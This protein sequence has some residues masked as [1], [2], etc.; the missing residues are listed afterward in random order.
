MA[1]ET[2]LNFRNVDS[3][4]NINAR[5]AGLIPKGIVKGGQVVPEPAS[6]QVRVKGD[7]I[8]PFVL[9]AFA[10]DGMVIREMSEEHVLP[11]TAG[12]TSV[13]VLRAKYVAAVGGTI[14]GFEMMSLGAYQT[15]PDQEALIRLCSISPPSGVTAVLTEHI[16]MG[17]RDSI[18]GFT[19]KIVRGVVDTKEDLPAVSGFPAQAEINFL[20]NTFA[21]GTTIT[22][23]TPVG[24]VAFPI[25]SAGSWKLASPNEPGLSRLNPSQK[26]VERDAPLFWNPDGSGHGLGIKRNAATGV[27]T[28]VTTEQHGFFDGSSNGPEVRGVFA[29]G[30]NIYAATL[31]GLAISTNSGMDWSNKIGNGLGSVYCYGVYVEDSTIYAATYAGLSISTDGGSSWINKNT[32][33]GLGSSLVNGVFVSGTTIYAATAGGLSISTDSG[34]TW[35]NKTT[36]NGIGSNVVYCVYASG[37]KIYAGTAGGLSISIDGGTTWTTKT[38][39]DGLGS[40]YVYG[41]FAV[42]SKIYAAT[43]GGLALS[44]DD[45]ATWSNKT[46]THGLG[47][48]YV[49]SVYAVGASIYAG[50]LGGLSIS[51]DNGLT[52]ANKTTTNGLGNNHVNSVYAVGARVY[53]A[54]TGGVS[55]S[56]DSG[57]TW[58]NTLTSSGAITTIRISECSNAKA[59]QL[60]LIKEVIDDYTFTVQDNESLDAWTGTGG[61][62]IDINVEAS[63]VVKL[64]TGI[65]HNLVPGLDR[66]RIGGASNPSFNSNSL[67]FVVADA[68]DSRTLVF[69]Q[70]GYPTADAG[71]G[72][73]S[74]EGYTIPN[75]GVEIGESAI[76]TAA[77]FER[78]LNASLLGTDI[79]AIAI[80]S[81]NQLE[82]MKLGEVGNVFTLSKI[83][84]GVSPANQTIILSGDHFSGGTDP[85]PS[86]SNIDLQAGDLYVVILGESGMLE[87]WGYDGSIFRNLT[88]AATATM[89]DFHRRNQFLNEGHITENQKDALVGT[90]GV[91]SATNKFVTA[92]DTSVLTTD[93]AAAL[94]GADGVAPNSGNRYLTEARRRGE[95]G[96]VEVPSGQ[97]WIPIPLSDGS[98]T[99]Q[100]IVGDDNTNPTVGNSSSKAIPFFN[101]VRTDTLL[102]A[103]GPTEYS[104]VDFT[105]V[106][107]TKV[108]VGVWP[109]STELLPSAH[110]DSSGV[111]PLPSLPSSQS[112]LWVQLGDP[113]TGLNKIPDNGSATLLFSRVIT[114]RS[115]KPSADMYAPPQRILPAALQD[116]I[117]KVNELRF[118]AG[119]SISA[120][121]ITSKNTILTFPEGL[122]SA[123]NVQGFTLR[124]VVNSQ[125]VS[126]LDAFSIDFEAGS[127]GTGLIEAFTPVKLPGADRWTKYLLSLTP[128]GKIKV[129]HIKD[130]LETTSDNAFSSMLSTVALPSMAFSDGSYTF[131]CIGVRLSGA[132]GTATISDLLPTSIEL[133]PYQGTNEREPCAPIICGDGAMSFGHFTGPDA[134]IR[135]LNLAKAG[136]TIRLAPGTYEG[137]LLISKSDITI[138]GSGGAVLTYASATTAALIVV[139]SR[140][141]LKDLIFNCPIALDIQG[142]ADNLS[143]SGIVFKANV[144]TKIK[145]PVVYTFGGSDVTPLLG[146][147]SVANTLAEGAYVKFY[148]NQPPLENAN[149]YFVRNPT[150]AYFHVSATSDGTPIVFSSTGSGSFG[151]GKIFQLEGE[152]QFNHWTV[153]DG[154]NKYGVGDFNSPSALQEVHDDA[155]AQAGD[156]I[157]VLPGTYKRLSVTRDKLHYKGLGGGHVIIDGE[158]STS[159]CITVYGSYNQFENFCLK[160]CTKGIECKSGATYNSFASSV[161][162]DTDIVTAIVIEATSGKHY[163]HHPIISGRIISGATVTQK[164]PEVTIG[165]GATSWGDYVGA[166]AIDQAISGESRGTKLL[167]RSGNYNAINSQGNS[168]NDFIIEGAGATTIIDAKGDADR[169]IK[170]VGSG[171]RISGVKLQ[172]LGNESTNFSTFG[173]EVTGSDNT[174]ENIRF[175]DIGSSRIEL[176]KRYNV[177]SG[178]RNRFTTHTGAATGYVNWTVGDGTHSFGD[179]VGSITAAIQALPTQPKGSD[180]IFSARTAADSN[181]R[182]TVIFQAAAGSPLTFTA[183]DL[184]R[185]LNINSAAF[186]TNIGTYRITGQNPPVAASTVESYIIA[187]RADLIAEISSV[188]FSNTGAFYNVAGAAKAIQL[189]DGANA[190]HY[191]WFKVTGGS[192]TQTDP[193]LSG[194]GHQ[195]SVLLADTPAQVATKFAAAVD[196]LAAFIAPVPGAAI[197][198]VTNAVAGAATDISTTGVELP[199]D[200]RP[201]VVSVLTQGVGSLD[202]KYFT[203]VHRATG[204]IVGVWF[205]AT[206]TTTQP[207]MGEAVACQVLI[208]SGASATDVALALVGALPP[209]LFSISHL[210]GSS[211]SIAQLTA[212][213]VGNPSMGTSGCEL[214]ITEGLDQMSSS[215]FLERTDGISFINEGGLTFGGVNW[216]F[217]TGSKI[218][219]LPGQ[220]Q[221]FSIPTSRND[222]DIEA[223]GGGGDTMIVGTD[224]TTTLLQIEG[225]RCRVKGF[226]FCGGDPLACVA[227]RVNGSNN[228]FEANRYETAIRYSFGAK[229]VGN[230]VYDAPEAVHR[231]YLTVSAYPSRADFVGSTHTAIQAAIDAAVVDSHINKVVLGQGEWILGS[232]ITVPTGIILEGSGYGTKLTG[233]GLFPALT[234]ASGDYQTIKCIRFNNF[235]KSLVSASGTLTK[236]FAY[237]NWLE[238]AAIDSSVTGQV[239]QN[240]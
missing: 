211:V 137:S 231:T 152:A 161:I 46:T 108:Y 126:L 57:L 146:R 85:N 116:I 81:S 123:S 167:V 86:T 187:C 15:E 233:T 148:G 169:C 230:K 140:C 220:Y 79:K 49:Y 113:I 70:A 186:P 106:V 56:S 14:S 2:L 66:I 119:I 111:F 143:I 110:A 219:V 78:V 45:G 29:A 101:V 94:A 128:Y 89:L 96:R 178:Y 197:V 32:A 30:T 84:P 142:G 184:Y 62:V 205:D 156:I 185:Y 21:L 223:W 95:I 28:V 6:L 34:T 44:S 69:F 132:T 8:S 73:I 202:G 59:N 149:S 87:L 141:T 163:N 199:T 191:F 153:S 224:L 217:T 80:G 9:L 105:P 77:N 218:W 240:L 103:G 122:F 3:T 182:S 171:N 5:L 238:S 33:S 196:T 36:T 22:I 43:Y 115:R 180:G 209:A 61:N 82:A 145:S 188:T 159:S 99:W 222:I 118:N 201:A 38:I 125:P 221:P 75:D 173:I 114:E 131:A 65:T 203:M 27:V 50:T 227:V 52:W 47:N 1:L 204:N 129:T 239:S 12:I 98:S 138:D 176:H 232:T 208:S 72:T 228:T 189:Y 37:S 155:R 11:V 104:Q 53:A 109:S 124:R 112:Q 214:F 151:D 23:G 162:F 17:F 192:N 136:T 74:K 127:E 71:N 39:S 19:R 16:N 88:S 210:G 158:N 51:T 172:A 13:L 183:N 200:T 97:S 168:F 10:S 195:V 93:M 25:V 157:T 144:Q 121:G 194:A 181:G 174:F 175:E 226:R 76:A 236:V 4:E 63:I 91:P 54:T 177:T 179:F 216:D 150:G 55:Y 190:G 90:V 170:V 147:I 229:A 40:S 68:P 26:S 117:N 165:D 83:E 134:H 92:S 234:L 60:W 20:K 164:N 31:G 135:A 215:C 102:S 207:A 7:G 35:I 160:N 212:G 24:A 225:S 18:E 166:D 107:V 58:A 139:G 41:V 120:S 67:S 198:T 206:G 154:S 64:E 237:N 130:L 213:S 235:S 133:Y 42:G 100:L 48:N 193:F